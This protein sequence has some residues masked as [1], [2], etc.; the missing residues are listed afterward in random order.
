[1]TRLPLSPVPLLELA[2]K[3]SNPA[4]V[5]QAIKAG[6]FNFIIEA[7]TDYAASELRDKNMLDGMTATGGLNL[8]R[9]LIDNIEDDFVKQDN[10]VFDEDGNEKEK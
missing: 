8:G 2:K 9:Q 1:M 3:T 10:V 4:A 7:W 5:R 6:V